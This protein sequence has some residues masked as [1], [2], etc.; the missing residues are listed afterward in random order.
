MPEDSPSELLSAVLEDEDEDG[1]TYDGAEELLA[2]LGGVT[3]CCG[4]DAAELLLSLPSSGCS[5]GFC[6]TPVKNSSS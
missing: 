1:G 6:E 3:G 2:L 5:S 4:C